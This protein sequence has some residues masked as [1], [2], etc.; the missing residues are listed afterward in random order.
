MPIKAWT[1]TS[2]LIDY[3]VVVFL[4]TIIDELRILVTVKCDAAIWHVDDVDTLFPLAQNR[5]DRRF[6]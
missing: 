4:R 2:V 3:I 1:W 6:T 5:A